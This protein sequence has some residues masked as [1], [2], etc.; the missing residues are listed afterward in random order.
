M[1]QKGMIICAAVVV[2]GTVA[3][4]I[5]PTLMQDIFGG[6]A[7]A[8][9]A[10]AKKVYAIHDDQTY[11][12]GTQPFSLVPL[13]DND[14]AFKVD[15]P[16]EWTND[17]V[18]DTLTQEL[19]N[20]ILYNITRFRSPMIGVNR[21]N[22]SIQALKLE[23]EITAKH[24][25]QNYI[26]S[27]GYAPQGEIIS[28]DRHTAALGFVWT[29]DGAASYGYMRV[30]I[31]GG[32]I[33]V[34]R[35][36][37][38]VSLKDYLSFIQQKLPDSLTLTYPVDEPVETQKAFALVDSIKFGYPLSWTILGSDF[39]DMNRLTVQLQNVSSRKI[40]GF[41][42]FVAVRRTR[43][44]SLR[45]ELENMRNYFKNSFKLEIAG[46]K[47]SEDIETSNRFIFNRYEVYNVQNEDKKRLP[48]ELHFAVLGDK[49]WYIFAFMIT[50]T[51]EDNLYT[52]ARNTESF[53]VV[54]RSVK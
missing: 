42:S 6:K 23:H 13:N 20:K 8:P 2:L 51:E 9:E 16:K 35:F 31:N 37:A 18:T 54:V 11:A 14:L 4:M 28:E 45:T 38:P 22:F 44:A 27:N 34:A 46:M 1:K 26:I 48:Q 32:K 7:A 30:R 24:W 25:L 12:E 39:R 47:S 5:R 3:F 33:I 41:I 52:W 15:V 19:D 50:P 49:E 21:A 43:S 40:D 29:S 17:N 36:D 10:A 53:H